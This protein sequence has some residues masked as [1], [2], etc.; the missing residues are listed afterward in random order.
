MSVTGLRFCGN[1]E[2]SQ[3]ASELP[4]FKPPSFPP[5]DGFFVSVDKDGKPLS[6][7]SDARWDFRA[8]NNCIFNFGIQQLTSENNDLLKQLTF[9]Y[10]YHMPLFP[11]KVTSVTPHYTML[12]RLCKL[13]DSRNITIDQL[14]RFPRLASDVMEFFTPAQHSKLIGTLNNLLRSEDVL[15]WKI[16]DAAFIEKLAR[17]EIPHIPTQ[18]AYIP[19][20]IWMSLIQSTV[21]V[22]DAFEKN[23]DALKDAWMW[24]YDAYRNNIENGF[25]QKSPFLH[26][27]RKTSVKGRMKPLREPRRVYPG[28]AKAFFENYGIADLLNRWVGYIPNQQHDLHAFSAYANLVRDCAFTFILA[29]SIQR[30]GEGLSLR[31]D[32]F[33]VDEDP[34]LGKV[35]LLVGETTKTDPDSDARWV[36]PMSV[37]RAVKILNFLGRLRLDTTFKPIAPEIQINPYLMTGKIEHWGSG[38]SAIKATQWDLGKLVVNNPIAFPVNEFTITQEDYK[39]AYQLTPLLTEKSWFK[40]GGVW[41]FNAHQLRRTLAV[42]LFAS[43]VPDS[44]I[45]WLMKHKTVHQSYY[46]GRNYTRLRINANTERTVVVEGYRT[47]VRNLIEAAE[48]TLGVSVHS[49]GKNLIAVTTLKLIDERDHKKL[50]ALAKK[51]EIAARPT[52]LGFCMTQSCEY[53]GVESAAHCAGVDGKAP[54]KDAVFSKRNGKRLKTLYDSNAKKLKDLPKNTPRHSKLKAENE[55]V[56]VYFHATSQER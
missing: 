26:P 28:G 50:E 10:L 51:G 2:S 9:L 3:V 47:V 24:L 7:Y 22:M 6:K 37:E 53:G 42:N 48:N 41:S 12:I 17:L 30:R 8:Y 40:V 11:G 14:Y 33:Q 29:H 23:Q 32:C 15:G 39:I 43:D 21:L 54:C 20:R 38:T 31:S 49:T 25:T 52:L 34:T 46:Y 5:P 56:E 13:A 36:V 16:A 1:L 18:N 35:A 44:V 19:S 55:A 4:N 27:E 45:Q